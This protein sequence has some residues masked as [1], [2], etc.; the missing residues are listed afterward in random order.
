MA[1]SLPLGASESSNFVFLAVIIHNAQQLNS[2]S[3]RATSKVG[4][5]LV[6]C[7]GVWWTI[8]QTMARNVKSHD[9]TRGLIGTAT[10]TA[11]P[12]IVTE[13]KCFS[14][15]RWLRC[16]A[17][18]LLL[19]D[20]IDVTGPKDRFFDKWDA[21][22]PFL[23]SQVTVTVISDGQ[24]VALRWLCALRNAEPPEASAEKSQRSYAQLEIKGESRGEP[25]RAQSSLEQLRAELRAA[26]K[27]F[28]LC[29]RSTVCSVHFEMKEDTHM[30][31]V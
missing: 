28:A 7:G 26:C 27:A 12:R 6:I 31:Q 3:T 22:S 1:D 20:G 24:S 17:K 14:D 19:L 15:S 2:T 9:C 13:R 23:Q 10:V 11:Q 8:N 30:K 4:L 16:R 5:L 25:G 18:A 29:L 21:F